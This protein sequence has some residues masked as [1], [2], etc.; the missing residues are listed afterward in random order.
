M[1]MGGS[2]QIVSCVDVGVAG[3]QQL[4]YVDVTSA[5]EGGGIAEDNGIQ[6]QN[7]QAQISTAGGG[8]DTLRLARRRRR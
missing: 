5:V 2:I 3:Q 6:E 1:R 4:D 8:D 7:L